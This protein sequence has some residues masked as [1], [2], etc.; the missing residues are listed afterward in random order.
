VLIKGDARP[1]K[2]LPGHKTYIVNPRIIPGIYVVYIYTVYNPLEFHIISRFKNSVVASHYLCKMLLA[3]VLNLYDI[4]QFK[5]FNEEL[6][7]H[8]RQITAA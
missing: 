4:L 8:T 1:C 2:A 7:S 3:A 5:S 6:D